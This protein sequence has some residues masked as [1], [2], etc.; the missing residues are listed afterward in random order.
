MNEIIEFASDKDAVC[1]ES[2]IVRKI[3]IAYD[4][5]INKY[6]VSVFDGEKES[7][8]LYY[9]SDYAVAKQLYDKFVAQWKKA[10]DARSDL[11]KN[12]MGNNGMAE[13]IYKKIDELKAMIGK[14]KKSDEHN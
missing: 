13:D 9:G 5:V 14:T 6:C 8:V 7:N 11:Y 2:S 4:L 3:T 12:S 1:V 10:E